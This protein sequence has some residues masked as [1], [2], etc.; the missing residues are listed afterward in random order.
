MENIVLNQSTQKNSLF[1]PVA[2]LSLFA[3]ASGYLMSLIPLSLTFFE[4]NTSLAPLLASIFYLGLLLGAPCI[5][6]IVA[7]IG[8]SKAFIL[9]LN[10]LLCSVVAMILIPQ[11]G[12]WLASRLVAGFAVAGVFVVVESWLLMADTQK[13][14]AKRLGL[15]MTAL[16]GGT[17]IGQ[18]AIDYLGTAGNL[19]YLVIM[20]LL[21]AASLPALLVKRGQ[22]IA[23]EQQSMSLS[24]LRNLSQPA[25]VGCLV[26]GLLLGP[27]YGLL[28]IYVAID[29]ALDRQTGLFMALII[30]GGMLV[31]PLVSYLSPR[32]NKSGL[33]MGF[34]LLGTAA[35]FLLTQYS[36]MSL[37]IGFLLLGASAFALYPIAI[38]L[39]CDDLPASQI[40][41]ATQVMLLSYSIG[42]VI[43]PLAASGFGQMEYG[44]L[45]YLGICCV[46]TSSY[47]FAQLV[48]NTKPRFS[49]L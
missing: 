20:G 10:I 16:Y 31:Q 46:L 39:A 47:L 38:S 6:P 29:M 12:V 32:V 21:A 19:P 28:P 27:I 1:V 44:L 18:L 42:S 36:N 40:V 30:L 34:C 22:P 25:I 2:G 3:L 17:A 33:I 24:G 11:S 26:S 49:S 48:I 9:F 45:I 37:I 4:L 43:G 23:S 14:R 7:R 35:L 5:A 13:Q 41:S 15:Y 8:H